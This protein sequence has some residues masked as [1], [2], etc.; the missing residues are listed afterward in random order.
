MPGFSY[1]DIVYSV[2]GWDWFTTDDIGMAAR[3]VRRLVLL[4]ALVPLDSGIIMTVR[5][6]AG[7]VR[8]FVGAVKKL[9]KPIVSFIGHPATAAVLSKVL[10]I[11]VA[12][13]RGMY[14]PEHHS[15][16][17]GH[18]VAIV[19]RLKKRLSRPEDVKNVTVDDL[20]MWLVW[21]I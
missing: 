13:N 5:V 15:F 14:Q 11:E 8:A 19:A 12:V 7:T 1:P 18:D 9:G 10:G 3:R 4:N 2:G 21:Y 20:E 6:D 16:S 17:D